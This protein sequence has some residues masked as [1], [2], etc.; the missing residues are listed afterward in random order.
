MGCVPLDSPEEAFFNATNVPLRDVIR[1]GLSLWDR[2]KDGDVAVDRSSLAASGE[3]PALSLLLSKAALPVRDYR[4]RLTR[5]R[6]QGFLAHRRYTFTER[7][8]IEVGSDEYIVLRPAWLLDRLC[9]SQLYWQTFFDFGTEKAPSG[10]QFSLAMNDV[11]ES[12]VAYLFRRIMRRARPAITLITEPEMQDAWK[13]GGDKPSVCDWV[14][15]S[16]NVCVLVDATNHWLDAQA[17]QG[18]ATPDGY[19]TDI[20]DTF[21]SRK[22]Q[23]LMSTRQRLLENGW[24]GCTFTEETVFVPVVVVPNAG[25]PAS[26]SADIDLKLRT[27]QLGPNVLSPG[28]L[29][30]R[31]LQVLERHLQVSGAQRLRSAARQVAGVVHHTS[32]ASASNVPRPVRTGPPSKHL[33]QCFRA[34]VDR[35]CPKC[36]VAKAGEAS[37]ASLG[38]LVVR[39]AGTCRR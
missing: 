24:D 2:T 7:P 11:F 25:I 4:K 5:E 6:R 20:E 10:E 1:M 17:A 37:L 3:P 38:H 21:V 9:G 19:S 8:L 36:R 27:G 35:S 13:K 23:Q 32:S 34:E 39:H 15:V 26:V 18:L 16:D 33:R 29:T 28:I 12:T 14:L 22:F 30:Y 31:D